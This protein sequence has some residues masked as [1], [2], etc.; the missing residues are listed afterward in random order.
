MTATHRFLFLVLS[1]GFL[2]SMLIDWYEQ[3]ATSCSRETADLVN[4][5]LTGV[6]LGHGTGTIH[7]RNIR[8]AVTLT[9][10]CLDFYLTIV[11]LK[12]QCCSLLK[13]HRLEPEFLVIHKSLLTSGGFFQEISQFL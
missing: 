12:Y 2:V 8:P 6:Y 3:S 7:S 1:A 4:L 5:F 13:Y 11:F 9:K 10:Q